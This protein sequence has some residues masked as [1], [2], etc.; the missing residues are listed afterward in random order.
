MLTMETLPGTGALVT[1][2]VEEEHTSHKQ[3][4][5]ELKLLY[6]GTRGLSVRSIRRFCDRHDI[7]ATSMLSDENLDTVVSSSVAKVG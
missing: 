5:D 6:P 1:N 4:S 7:R 2:W 3:I